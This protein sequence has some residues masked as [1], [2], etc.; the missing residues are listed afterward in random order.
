MRL[1]SNNLPEFLSWT[2]THTHTH[3]HAQSHMPDTSKLSLRS[4]NLFQFDKEELN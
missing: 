4:S 1:P 3:T 2:H